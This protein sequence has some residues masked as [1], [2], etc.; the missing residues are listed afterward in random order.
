MCPAGHALPRAAAASARWAAPRV[1]ED[2]RRRADAITWTILYGDVA[3][4]DVDIAIEA[5]R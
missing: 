5:L 2:L 1:D 4:V 3:A